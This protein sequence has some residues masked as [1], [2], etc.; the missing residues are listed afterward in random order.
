MIQNKLGEG[1]KEFCSPE[2][3]VELGSIHIFY[4]FILKKP[5]INMLTGIKVWRR[6]GSKSHILSIANR[7][8]ILSSEHREFEKKQ[9][10]PKTEEEWPKRG[11]QRG[12]REAHPCRLL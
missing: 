3:D 2:M 10:G 7:K 11:G 6:K 5:S 9:E 8:K 4:L 1:D 12:V